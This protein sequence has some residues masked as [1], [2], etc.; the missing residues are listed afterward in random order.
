[1][2]QAEKDLFLVKNF[3][4]KEVINFKKF[5]RK[6]VLIKTDRGDTLGLR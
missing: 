5:T 4:K 3:K 2:G 6:E 1:L